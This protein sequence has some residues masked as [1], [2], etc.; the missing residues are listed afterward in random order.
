MFHVK[1][2]KMGEKVS[3]DEDKRRR[4]ALE[5]RRQL[6]DG[7]VSSVTVYA[8]NTAILERSGGSSAIPPPDAK[9]GE[10]KELT[11]SARARMLFVM[12]CTPIDFRSMITL[13]YPEEF[14]SDGQSSKKHLQD[15]IRSLIHRYGGYYFW[16]LEFQNRGAPHYHVF[17][18]RS[19]V[20][21]DD[22]R[23]LALRWA[24]CLQVSQGRRYTSLVDRREK[25]MWLQIL[26]FNT[27]PKVWETIRDPDG[28][29]RY[30]AKYALKP[31]QKQVPPRYQSV[32]RFYGYSRQVKKLI[33]PLDNFSV[34]AETIRS[35]LSLEG[36]T[37][38]EWE[39][40]PKYLFN[41][42][43]FKELT[44]ML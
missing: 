23:W 41:V 37:A 19:K 43:S 39:F 16:F 7:M 33:E 5:Y 14:P 34:S 13:T 30:C 3:R 12:T 1:Q 9:R 10:I 28:A 32:G 29:R 26:R 21:S 40:L 8:N 31:Y 17:H 15:F 4:E 24:E 36:H 38:S 22:R 42:Q 11:A 25:D 27:H 18:T 35:V 20:H 6:L 2:S 44:D